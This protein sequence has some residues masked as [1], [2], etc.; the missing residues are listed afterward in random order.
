MEGND[1]QKVRF[2]DPNPFGG[3]QPDARASAW[4]FEISHVEVIPLR[5]PVAVLYNS[6]H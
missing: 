2:R 3:L 5:R 4:I 6:L 1:K